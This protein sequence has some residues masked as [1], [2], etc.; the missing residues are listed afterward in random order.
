MA[1]PTR[2]PYSYERP[3]AA[4][5]PAQLKAFKANT[6]AWAFYQ[7]QAP[8]YQ[9]TARRW[10]LSA[11]REETRQRRFATLLGDCAAGRRLKASSAKAGRAG[12][13]GAP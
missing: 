12:G 2:R 6:G 5:P 4:F 9:R 3:P 1:S 11:K 7:A 13:A 10:V 8:W